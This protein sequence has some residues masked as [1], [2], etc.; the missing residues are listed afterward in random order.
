M[1]QT[2]VIHQGR[3]KI[4]VGID[5]M[6]NHTQRGMWVSGME[7]AGNEDVTCSL[8]QEVVGLGGDEEKKLVVGLGVAV[9]VAESM[10]NAANV[11]GIETVAAKA[12][13]AKK[14][15]S[16]IDVPVNGAELVNVLCPVGLI[17]WGLADAV[18]V[19]KA[20]TG[21]VWEVGLALVGECGEERE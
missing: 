4:R 9:G 7:Q 16:R 10:D 14:V 3:N 1:N 2:V 12:N 8:L 6:M 18:L 11:K 15:K 5:Q 20:D 21:V 13:V 17:G 19:F